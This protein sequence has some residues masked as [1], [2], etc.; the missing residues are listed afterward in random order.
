MTVTRI[1]LCATLL[2]ACR[3]EAVESPSTDAATSEIAS[4]APGEATVDVGSS[5][6]PA[7]N[8]FV[9]VGA[10]GWSSDGATIEPISGP[11]GGWGYRFK[12]S[13]SYSS[14]SREVFKTLKAG[15]RLVVRVYFKASGT[16]G[17]PP[18]LLVRAIHHDD[19]GE[20][21][22]DVVDMNGDAATDWKL[23]EA[24]GTLGSDET[25]LTVSISSTSPTTDEF[26][27]GGVSIVT[28]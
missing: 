26:A 20:V 1:L 11:C 15:A 2:V 16:G 25:S 28:E 24:R 12:G 6:D 14:V 8:F 7:G 3:G 22:S 18:N 17:P 27:F 19:A 10:G 5:C 9:D 13:K 21:R 4:D 23:L